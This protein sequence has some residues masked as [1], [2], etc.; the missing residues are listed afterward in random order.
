VK[1]PVD[2]GI[3]SGAASLTI[4][5][6]DLNFDEISKKLNVQPTKC[7]K[8]GE[9]ISSSGAI[10]STDFWTYKVKLKDSNPVSPL[11][12]L[13]FDLEPNMGYIH[14][15]SDIG[16]GVSLRLYYQSEAAQIYFE[17]PSD[18]QSLIAKFKVR[19]EV[20]ILSWGGAV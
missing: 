13:I 11:M 19:L 12:K 5:G 18:L 2:S 9:M 16:Y 6:E 20:S 7:L 14:H 10:M 1:H 15:L 3:Y 8:K 4:R 17:I